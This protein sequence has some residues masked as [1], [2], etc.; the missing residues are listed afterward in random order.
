MLL[1][2]RPYKTEVR[3]C[4]CYMQDCRG[5]FLAKVGSNQTVC[6]QELERLNYKNKIQ[7]VMEI[8]EIRI[9]I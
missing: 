4:D 5:R 9:S 2:S 8:I 6:F 3:L 1:S 7:P